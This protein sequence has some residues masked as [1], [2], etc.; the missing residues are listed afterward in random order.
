VSRRKALRRWLRWRRWTAAVYRE[1][2]YVPLTPAMRKAL[3][4]LHL[5]A[6]RETRFYRAPDRRRL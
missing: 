1:T 3:R 5:I 4:A 6:M 2:D